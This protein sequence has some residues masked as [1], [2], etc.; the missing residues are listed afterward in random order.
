MHSDRDLE[1]ASS[2]LEK[3][4]VNREAYHK[5]QADVLEKYAALMES[6]KRL[7]SDYEEERESREKYKQLAKGQE[8]NPFVLV[9]HRGFVVGTKWLA[10]LDPP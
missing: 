8:R 3:F 2:Q 10:G 4:H 1:L 6:Y 7:R 5:T 9:S